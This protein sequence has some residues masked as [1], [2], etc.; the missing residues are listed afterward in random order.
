MFFLGKSVKR[1]VKNKIPETSQKKKTGNKSGI[2]SLLGVIYKSRTNY[3]WRWENISEIYGCKSIDYFL[4]FQL[5]SLYHSDL[6]NYSFLFCKEI[7]GF[8]NDGVFYSFRTVIIHS[9]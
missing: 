3:K 9:L 6:I 4:I 5:Q 1:K 8:D 7:T 2:F